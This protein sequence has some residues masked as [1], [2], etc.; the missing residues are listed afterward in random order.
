[1]LF[2][3][4][5]LFAASLC[6]F[7]TMNLVQFGKTGPPVVAS[8]GLQGSGMPSGAQ[9]IPVSKLHERWSIVKKQC[10]DNM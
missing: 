6:S 4:V 7:E 9:Q 1:M 3:S 8:L 10:G 5:G 2:F